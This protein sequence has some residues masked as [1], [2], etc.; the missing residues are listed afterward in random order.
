MAAIHK[1]LLTCKKATFLA[2]QQ[3]EIKLGWKQHVQLKIHLL[4][5]KVCAVFNKQIIIIDAFTKQ[6]AKEENVPN[7]IE[8]DEKQ[9]QQLEKIITENS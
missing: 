9:K 3:Q 4:L 1:I 8:L 7:C 6:L 5:C 2:V